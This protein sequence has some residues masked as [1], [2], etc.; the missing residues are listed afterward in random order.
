[1]LGMS[2]GV[3]Y[4]FYHKNRD[5]IQTSFNLDSCD[6]LIRFLIQSGA[7]ELKVLTGEEEEFD[8]ETEQ[9]TNSDL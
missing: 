3:K 5:E 4:M 8:Y 6:A 1:M 9:V 2:Q 7:D